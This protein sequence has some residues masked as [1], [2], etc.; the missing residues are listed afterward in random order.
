MVFFDHHGHEDVGV[1]VAVVL[2]NDVEV[3]EDQGANIHHLLVGEGFFLYAHLLAQGD[4]FVEELLLL[5]ELAR[6]DCLLGDLQFLTKVD[7]NPPAFE[8]DF[9][10]GFQVLVEHGFGEADAQD[11]DG[12]ADVW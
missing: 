3:G 10:E 9:E 8:S 5:A 2:K 12:L 6:V 7:D 4:L 11:L 1:D